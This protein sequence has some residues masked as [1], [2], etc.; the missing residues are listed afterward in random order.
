MMME[1]SCLIP[2]LG[3]ALFDSGGRTYVGRWEII[4]RM[5]KETRSLCAARGWRMRRVLL[6]KL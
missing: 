4:F 1:K 6:W 2:I 5:G 3:V